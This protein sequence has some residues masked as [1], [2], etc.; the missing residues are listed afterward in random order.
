MLPAKKHKYSKRL[1]ELNLKSFRYK[2]MDPCIHC[3]ERDDLDILVLHIRDPKHP[4][5][6]HFAVINNML[7][8]SAIEQLSL[9]EWREHFSHSLKFVETFIRVRTAFL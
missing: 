6:C 5:H 4:V 3:D 1:N 8:L 9:G 2:C 7:A